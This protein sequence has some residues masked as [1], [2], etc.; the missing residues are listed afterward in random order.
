MKSI[1]IKWGLAGVLL[2][3]A[4]WSARAA[5]H[6]VDANGANPS[7]PFTNWATAATTI[8]DAVDAST[9]GDEV[10]V[11][12]GVYAA[13]GR[14]I[15]GSMTNRVAITNSL[16]VHSVNGPLF[17]QI[18]GR[19]V[20][21]TLFGDGA[22]RC[23]YLASGASL[24]GFTLTNGATRGAGHQILE[25]SGGGIWC[26]YID[27]TVSNCIISGNIAPWMG[28]GA[29]SGALNNC[30]V[31][32]NSATNT[33]GGVC[34]NLLNNCT[35][36][37][38]H[39][40]YG[41][42]GAAGAILRNCIIYFNSGSSGPN[43]ASSFFNSCCT[44]PAPVGGGNIG[45]DP[46]FVDLAA[47]NLRLQSN[48]PCINAGNNANAPP[49]PDLDGNP[50]I[51]DGAVDIGAYEFQ[52]SPGSIAP[53]INTQPTNQAVGMGSNAT[54]IVSAGGALPLGYQWRFYGTNL[55]GATTNVLALTNV[56]PA[57]AGEY[58]AVITNVYGAA[59][60]SI[61]VLTLTNSGPPPSAGTHYVDLN[62]SNPVAPY[63]N[64]ATASTTIQAAV[65]VA[66]PGDEIVVTNGIYA[67]GAREINGS[68]RVAVTKALTL[69]SVNGPE[70]TIIQGYQLPG[71][72][73][74]DGAIRCV[75]LA[76][77]A[78]LYGFNLTQGATLSFGGSYDLRWNGGGALSGGTN[79]VISNCVMVANS[80]GGLG[81]GADLGK[82]YNCVLT[83]NSA[84]GGGGVADATVYNSVLIGNSADQ[85][86]ASD[87][88][89]LNNC[90]VAS[91]SAVYGGGTYV[92]T[93]NNCTVSGNSASGSGGGTGYS[94]VNNSIVYFNTAP[95]DPNYL[96]NSSY[97]LNYTC[98]TPLP[99]DGGGNITS[100][101]LFLD[102]A[103]GNFRIPSNSPCINAGNNLYAP[104]GPDLDGNPRIGGSVVD[105]GAYEFQGP[106]AP[107]IV[108][109]PTNQT[110]NLGSNAL[111][112]VTAG[113]TAPLKYQWRFGGTNVSGA[114][115]NALLLANVQPTDAGNY[116][117]VVTNAYGAVTSSVAV[118]TV[119]SNVGPPPTP[120]TRYVNVNSLNP[121]AP[122]TN[123]ATA[124]TRIQ[125][126]VDV[127]VAGDEVVVTNGI[128][129]SGGRPVTGALTNRVAVTK[130]LK[131][132][133]VNGP[134]VTVI[135]GWQVPGTTNGDGAIR[136][137]YLTNGASLAGFTLTNGATRASGD[138][139]LEQEAGG[140]Y[141]A[142][143]SVL[144]SN[145]VVAG[146]AA[147]Y[148]AS[149]VIYGTL[150]SCTISGNS[151]SSYAGVVYESTMNNCSL[152]NNS[153]GGSS[154]GFL[155]NCLLQ[156]NSNGGA[157]FGS[158][159]NCT[160]SGNSAYQGGG[161]FGS[162]LINCRLIDNSASQ[163]GGGAHMATLFNCLLTGNSAAYGGGASFSKLNNCTV[164]NNWATNGGGVYGGSSTNGFLNN[165]IVFFNS[166]TNGDNYVGGLFNYSCTAPLPVAGSGNIA[167]DPL[168]L[169]LPG[170]DVRL[171]ANSP[172]INSGSNG[173]ASGGPDLGGNTRIVG[174]VVDMG[175][176]EFQGPFAHGTRFVN[177]NSATPAPPYT[178]WS[179]AALTIQDAVDVAAPGD[180]II[181]T[182]GTYSAG[183]RI[184]Y[185]ALVNR[186]AVHRPLAVHS[187]NG[188]QVTVI[189][190]LGAVRCVYL[191]NGASLSGFAL[192]NG[193]ALLSGD[194]IKEKSGGGV[195][196]ESSGCLVSN[197]VISEC[198]AIQ[199]GGGAYSG[200]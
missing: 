21:G 53:Y 176:Y 167:A 130:P 71:I 88:A 61:A 9:S 95:S 159:S 152:V 91:N 27:A 23:V 115:T 194:P 144:V 180:E 135:Q 168:F 122:Y 31:M 199:N 40:M 186:V 189:D 28:G 184:I 141:C 163:A 29:Y 18:Q 52:G 94:T 197:C 185:G 82:L 113:G 109:Q 14:A 54:F 138:L 123:W 110:V 93:L 145:C 162:T 158:L 45:G 90:L 178:N 125:D 75:Y 124:A 134:Q 3:I 83:G 20:P 66:A 4:T 96:K 175:A 76:N 182:N 107:Y 121:T 139:F 150:D 19:Q 191:T 195:W 78:R 190:G 34:S 85:G 164:V 48:S 13:G 126:A 6:Y 47:G 106:F 72:T 129:A 2:I 118:L 183:G 73:N 57:N 1:A 147:A 22:I 56:Q 142:S 65:D 81:G 80:A 132:R 170:G 37:S 87:V 192:T 74:G 38:N 50:R 166:A 98:T 196:A 43:H 200:T 99:P 193:Y 151:A 69:R 55:N 62:S 120:G 77:G 156:G 7:P 119:V 143:T 165:C 92:S 116:F 11:T 181:V 114:T 173:Y 174:G 112:R 49:G 177:V 160:L 105:V 111:F 70:F 161:A 51:A 102:M 140:I 59:T 24:S 148:L 44:T 30:L 15:F 8:Q 131:L 169:D 60:S 117:A 10:I 35:I 104:A 133:S 172:C 198:S 127:A 84:Q 179:T 12:N 58:S 5:V 42:G 100:A 33:G 155:V 16:T 67:T 153:G 89:T 171:Q 86:G 97:V 154:W 26:P 146:N 63:T 149:A 46:L 64:W 188:P 79:V 36:A 32:G 101:P 157:Y 187:V 128:Y 137:A 17:T 136:C 25:Q 39:V 68:N 103:A 41:A 108:S